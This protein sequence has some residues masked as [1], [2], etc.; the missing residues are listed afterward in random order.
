MLPIP[1]ALR[2]QFE[3]Y[4]RTRGVPNTEQA[5][6]VKWLRYY[7]DFCSKYH[8]PE[9]QRGSLAHFLHKL[10]EKRQTK[11]Q[12]QQASDAITRYYELLYSRASQNAG[13]SPQTAGHRGRLPD[14]SPNRPALPGREASN[15]A[16]IRPPEG[17]HQGSSHR[18]F[19][20]VHEA[21]T[22][23]QVSS[24]FSDS[25]END[26]SESSHKTAFASDSVNR[27]TGVSWREVYA[28]LSQEIKVRHYSPKTLRNYTQWLQQFQTFTRSKDPLLLSSVE[29][30]ELL[31]HSH[32][33]TTMIYKHTVKSVTIKEAR[34]PLDL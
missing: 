6:Y 16:T 23:L 8:F 10:E 15:S 4:L 9:D 27:S 33:K 34:S 18:P 17:A 5:A 11:A 13:P 28:R 12:Q 31:G 21:N 30:K 32:L 14:G 22:S 25:S 26:P 2:T 3:G 7:L 24:P 19:L 29:V 20:P 1:L